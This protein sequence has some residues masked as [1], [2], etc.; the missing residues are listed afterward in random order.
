LLALLPFMA[1]C[2][3]E[4]I[5]ALGIIGAGAPVCYFGTMPDGE[6]MLKVPLEKAE[7]AVIATADEMEI[8]IKDKK[9][10]KAGEIFFSG[11]SL[12]HKK[13][14]ILLTSFAKDLTKVQ[15]KARR[16]WF[17]FFDGKDYAFAAEIT[18]SIAA[19]CAGVDGYLRNNAQNA[20]T[21]ATNPDAVTGATIQ[22]ANVREGPGVNYKVVAVAPKGA[23]LIFLN[24]EG[25]WLK[26]KLVE[27]GR[28]GYIYNTLVRPNGI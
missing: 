5:A 9:Q 21:E 8:K 22:M 27:T 16:R 4:T 7:E 10:E 15:I 1:G 20:L 26:V 24:E 3:I 18:T 23:E 12:R 14:Q 6:G 2:G 11:K 28:I 17:P 25:N 13:I 19:K